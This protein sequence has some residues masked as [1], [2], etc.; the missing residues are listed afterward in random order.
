[1]S[2]QKHRKEQ[3]HTSSPQDKALAGRILMRL[4]KLD[5]EVICRFYL[6]RQPALEI[7]RDLDLETG[8][9]NRLKTSV[10]VRFFEKRA[11]LRK[12]MGV[13]M[14][15]TAPLDGREGLEWRFNGDTEGREPPT[16][17]SASSCDEPKFQHG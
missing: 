16:D 14:A 8:Y 3:P 10:K 13:G 6:D 7:E 15:L 9:V 2:F 4:S 12:P 1:M 11:V 5:K 17:A